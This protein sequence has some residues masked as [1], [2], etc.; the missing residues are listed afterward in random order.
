MSVYSDF[1]TKNIFEIDFSYHK[2][3]AYSQE[4]KADKKF[5]INKIF[6]FVYSNV[7]QFD[8]VMALFLSRLKKLFII[9]TRFRNEQD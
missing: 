7:S 5:I 6:V 4:K 3:C 1:L 9:Y 2:L 8:N